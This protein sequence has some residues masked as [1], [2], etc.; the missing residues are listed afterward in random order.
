M[1]SLH[2]PIVDQRWSKEQGY[3]RN[4]TYTTVEEFTL[5][6][7]TRWCTERFT[8]KNYKSMRLPS[9]LVMASACALG[10]CQ[11]CFSPPA[12]YKKQGLGTRL[13]ID[14][15]IEASP[16]FN[17]IHNLSFDTYVTLPPPPPPPPPPPSTSPVT[18]VCYISC[19]I[20]IIIYYIARNVG[21]RALRGWKGDTLSRPY[22]SKTCPL[23]PILMDS[24]WVLTPRSSTP[25]RE[26]ILSKWSSGSPWRSPLQ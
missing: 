1:A 14:A 18:W 5:S 24:W 22:R 9:V 17:D 23:K 10:P 12:T 11:P 16:V 3:V 19:T 26:W 6:S 21:G 20:N 13:I 15:Y 8:N 2:V 4:S 25:T 7:N